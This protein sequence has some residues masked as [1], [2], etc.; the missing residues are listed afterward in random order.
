L[1]Y[2][3]LEKCGVEG[4]DG[5]AMILT[6]SLHCIAETLINLRK[7]GIRVGNRHAGGRWIAMGRIQVRR[8]LSVAASVTREWL[9]QQRE[10]QRRA[11]EHLK[12]SWK[13]RALSKDLAQALAD[14]REASSW[15]GDRLPVGVEMSAEVESI[16]QRLQRE[17]EAWG[18]QVANA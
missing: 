9:R 11:L 15:P 8:K 14:S 4:Q 10:H 7:T 16:T 13:I 12:H 1:N 6:R 2:Q 17:T 5:A 18:A 3:Y